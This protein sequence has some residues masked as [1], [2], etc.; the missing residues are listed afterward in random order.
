MAGAGG[1]IAP[2]RKDKMA[3]PKCHLSSAMLGWHP[4]ATTCSWLAYTLPGSEPQLRGSKDLQLRNG[5]ASPAFQQTSYVGREGQAS[6]HGTGQHQH[7]P[8]VQ[9]D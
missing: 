5:D 2:L 3:T 4:E 6:L 1:G 9:M 8:C 7:F